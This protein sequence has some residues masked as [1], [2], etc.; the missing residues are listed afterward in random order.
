[1]SR[2]GKVLLAT[3]L[4]PVA[5]LSS[6]DKPAPKTEVKAPFSVVEAS[7]PDMQAAMKD[8]RVTSKD[9]VNQYLA[10]IGLYENKLHATISVNPNAL[11]QAEALDK[12]RAAG[13]IRGPLHGI[14]I[15]IKDNIHTATDMPPPAVPLRS[16]TTGHPTTLRW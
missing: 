12:E 16:A 15:A 6:C 9:L 8:G 2:L 3:A 7:I 13:K 1:M 14:P 4:A 11:A 5:L 10:R